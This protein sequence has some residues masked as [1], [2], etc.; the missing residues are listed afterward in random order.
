MPPVFFQ[1]TLNVGGVDVEG[2]EVGFQGQRALSWPVKPRTSL[3]KH[4]LGPSLGLG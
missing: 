2:S 3:S 4:F 1:D